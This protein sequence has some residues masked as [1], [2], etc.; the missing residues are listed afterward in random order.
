MEN[1]WDI[2]TDAILDAV[3]ILPV[4]FIVYLIIE[5]VESKGLGKRKLKTLLSSKGAPLFGSVIGVIPQCGFSVIATKLYR[6]D[7]ILMGT[8]LSV[9]IA[10]SDEAIPIL[11]SEAFQSPELWLKLIILIAIKLVYAV[12]VGFLVNAF[13]RKT[14][15]KT[16]EEAE[17]EHDDAACHHHEGDFDNYNEGKFKLLLHPL[18]HSLK[19]FAYILAINLVFGLLIGF[20]GEDKIIAFLDANLFLQP[21]FS[22]LIGLIPNC[23][24]SVLITKMYAE[25]ALSLGGAVAGLSV[26][27]GLGFAILLKDGKSLKNTLSVISLTAL[28]SILIGYIITAISLLI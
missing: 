8:L 2:L 19:I 11:F 5:I 23:A 16:T 28:F 18:L 15:L 27:C 10:T 22:T 17:A 6:K 9:Y 20:I 14:V 3:K 13:A 24:S 21:L 25:S 26:N 12:I 1:L 7:Y 4:I